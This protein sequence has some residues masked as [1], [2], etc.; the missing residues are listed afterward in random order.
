MASDADTSPTDTL[1]LTAEIVASYLGNAAH[2]NAA[3][4]PAI[5]RNV[6]AALS[7]GSAPA[8]SEEA[9][10][11]AAPKMHSATVKKSITPDAL[12]SFID[13]KPYKTLKRHLSRHGHDMKE[14]QG[15]LRPA[16]GLPLGGAELQRGALGDG[17]EARARGPRQNR[18][19][20]VCRRGPEDGCRSEGSPKAGAQK[21]GADRFGRTS[22]DGRDLSVRRGLN[23]PP[24]VRRYRRAGG[25]IRSRDF[26]ARLRSEPLRR[27]TVDTEQLTEDRLTV[28]LPAGA[29]LAIERAAIQARVAAVRVDAQSHVGRAAQLGPAV[30]HR[31]VAQPR[32]LGADS[33]VGGS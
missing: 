31:A 17:Q 25:G 28:R 11:T 16:E 23:Q 20:G 30:R 8:V 1:T 33:G 4:I 27:R 5:I 10:P 14:L 24:P 12:I 22:R 9:A 19:D 3:D 21:G 26:A 15:S 29:A 13:N 32:S 18:V 2:V 6:R 7:E